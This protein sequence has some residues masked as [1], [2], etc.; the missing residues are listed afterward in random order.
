MK[1]IMM[2]I[3]S[4]NFY[5]NAEN[6]VGKKP[7]FCWASLILG[8]RDLYQQVESDSNF[9]KAYY[10]SALADRAD[11]PIKYD[12]QKRFLDA[13]ARLSF[14]EVILGYLM[15]KPTDE[16][17]PIDKNNPAT[18]YHVEK[19]TDVNLSND[20][21]MNAFQQKVD[22]ALLVAADGDF[23]DTIAKARTC[24]IEFFLV[25]PLGSPA[26][27]LKSLIKPENVI[28]LDERFLR[29]FLL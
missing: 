26:S 5:K 28:H 4:N 18:Y 15:R 3:D 23:E 1:K 10:Y 22:V 11:N 8:I 7:K 24:G 25:L 21:L 20:I 27:K 16:A 2:F 17:V 9:I 14:V 12:A 6:L 19:G 13:I 29:T